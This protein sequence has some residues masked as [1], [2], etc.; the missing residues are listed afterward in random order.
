MM[1]RRVPTRVAHGASHKAVQP[2]VASFHSTPSR[3]AAKIEAP[4]WGHYKRDALTDSKTRRAFTYAVVGL[5]G[6][7]SFYGIKS[8]V[9]DFV[10]SMNASADVLALANV[11]VDLNTIPAGSA[12]TVKWRGKPL[13]VRH[14][15]E[16][17]ISLATSVPSAELKDPEADEVRRKK[18]EWMVLLGVCTHLGCVP[19]NNSGDY[20]GWFC[21]CHG[22]HYDTRY[23]NLRYWLHGWVV[24]EH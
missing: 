21:P 11:E 2:R 14:R 24:L 20:K 10:D 4:S 5:A 16:E 8:T 6:S 19:I 1:L 15:T 3:A 17:E 13:F 9:L 23:I 12:I 22:S 18:P 7:T